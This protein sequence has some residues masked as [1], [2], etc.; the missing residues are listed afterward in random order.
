MNT[1]IY[2]V[3]KTDETPFPTVEEIAVVLD[4]VHEE[5]GRPDP[6]TERDAYREVISP[7]IG[8]VADHFGCDFLMVGINVM[9]FLEKGILE[10]EQDRLDVTDSV[11]KSLE[12]D[13]WTKVIW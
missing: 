13:S 5:C 8:K 4:G 2:T 12:Q 10:N 3:T 6:D 11:L 9:V 7:I 1:Y